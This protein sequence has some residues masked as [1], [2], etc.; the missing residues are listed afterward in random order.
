MDAI[1]FHPVSRAFIPV[2]AGDRTSSCPRFGDRTA[3][4]L[5]S[6]DDLAAP[7]QNSTACCCVACP[8]PARHAGAQ[9]LA[10]ERFIH[11]KRT[12]ISWWTAFTVSTGG[13]P[14]PMPSWRVMR[15]RH[16][17]QT[18]AWWSPTPTCGCGD[19]RGDRGCAP[20][21][22]VVCVVECTGT[23]P[24]VHDVPAEAMRRMRERWEPLPAE[25]GAV[26][27]SIS[28]D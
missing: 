3:P 22:P 15:W 14:T 26:S 5:K 8:A 9:R 19:G 2:D 10:L 17:R 1:H 23:W 25:F 13:S 7:S 21:Q 27:F 6:P 11:L 12:T 24:N 18:G 28:A 4:M 16:C 20:R